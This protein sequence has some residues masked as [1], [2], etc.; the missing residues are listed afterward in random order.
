MLCWQ[1]MIRFRW[2]VTGRKGAYCLPQPSLT[3]NLSA[4]DEHLRAEGQAA[5]RGGQAQSA[6]GEGHGEDGAGC[7]PHRDMSGQTPSSH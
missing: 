5:G 1:K 3:S 7:F 4:G 6:G 2:A